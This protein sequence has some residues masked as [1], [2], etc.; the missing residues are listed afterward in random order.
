M[1]TEMTLRKALPYPLCK[2][3]KRARTCK[4]GIQLNNNMLPC[5]EFY[6]PWWA[7]PLEIVYRAI[8]GNPKLIPIEGKADG[9]ERTVIFE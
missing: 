5:I 4:R 6:V 9:I 2:W 7:W 3:W 1:K 8:F